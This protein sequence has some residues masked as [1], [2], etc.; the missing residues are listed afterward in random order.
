[1][2][3]RVILALLL[4]SGAIYGQQVPFERILNREQG[5]TELGDLRR[6]AF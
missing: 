1:M 6:N 4:A 2:K 3:L 5:T